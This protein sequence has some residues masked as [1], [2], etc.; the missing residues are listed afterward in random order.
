MR[1]I[2]TL[3]LALACS[4]A[5][6][7]DLPAQQMVVKAPPLATP[8]GFFFGGN[9]IG[10]YANQSAPAMGVS[11]FADGGSVGAQMGYQFWQ[12]NL[13]FSGEVFGDVSAIA[14][15][16]GLG[17]KYGYVAGEVAKVGLG[18]AGL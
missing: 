8:S 7:A 13:F 17:Y 5:F 3:F 16:P 12:N 14:N 15:G 4:A 6:A 18:L 11:S 1:T 9:I 2:L 10:G